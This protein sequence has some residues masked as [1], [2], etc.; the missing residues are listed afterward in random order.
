[1]FT[2]GQLQ[3][4]KA[5]SESGSF[6]KAARKL[7][8]SQPAISQRVRA[9][10]ETLGLELFNRENGGIVPTPTRQGLE[11]L[12]F[13][14][15]TLEGYEALTRNLDESAARESVVTVGAV[16][17]YL[18]T[19]ILPRVLPMIH[20]AYP[21]I[22]LRMNTVHEEALNEAVLMGMVDL[23]FI[24]KGR[25]AP[26]LEWRPLW[27]DELIMVSHPSRV[28][29]LARHPRSLPLILAGTHPAVDLA[30]QWC[31][32][33]GAAPQVVVE[34]PN[35]DTLRNAALANLG[36]ALLPGDRRPRGAGRRCIGPG[37]GEG[38]AISPYDRSRLCA[39][40]R[41]SPNHGALP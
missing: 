9:L 28:A 2:F 31:A 35:A 11:V 29:E 7:Y 12:K 21:D 17:F 32:D 25:V 34:A 4:L 24:A 20:Q 1:M 3:T 37:A 10:E 36:Y 19:Y 26:D 5:I 27:E 23:V 38:P 13:A 22:K 30:R 18:G 41:R 14:L 39:G 33:I 15:A 40:S 6:T 8:L 16:G